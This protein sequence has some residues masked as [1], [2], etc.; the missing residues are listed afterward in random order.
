MSREPPTSERLARI[1]RRV[2]A[3]PEDR[4][5][6]ADWARSALRET[7]RAAFPIAGPLGAPAYPLGGFLALGPLP[8]DSAAQLAWSSDHGRFCRL[9]ALPFHATRSSRDQFLKAGA[10][11]LRAGSAAP[12]RLLG[13]GIDSGRAFSAVDLDEDNS[14]ILIEGEPEQRSRALL[15]A[16]RAVIALGSDRP[17]RAGLAL[18]DLRRDARGLVI[19]G[20]ERSVCFESFGY[21]FPGPYRPRVKDLTRLP[22]DLLM[23]RPFVE[24]DLVYCFGHALFEIH[25]GRSPIRAA[26]PMEARGQVVSLEFHRRWTWRGFPVALETL[27]RRALARRRNDRHR[28]LT[29][30]ADGLASVLGV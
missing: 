1:E 24:R 18:E 7:P 22:P 13:W 23:H 12:T 9:S 21:E 25:T 29:E 3:D 6:L 14:R 30:F 11:W 26:D 4:G 28:S 20:L 16:A 19:L 15:E 2:A 17:L 5:A 10:P 27:C 8:G